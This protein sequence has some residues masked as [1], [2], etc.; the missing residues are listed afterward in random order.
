MI[1]VIDLFC[2]VGGLTHGF[3]KEGYNVVAGI[4]TDH[5]C[6][7]AYV[8]NNGANFLRQSVA[9]TT[10]EE[11]C[12]LYAS[13]TY[14]VLVGC[15]PCQQFSLYNNHTVLNDKWNLLDT[16]AELVRQAEP[17]VVSMENVAELMKYSI[18]RKFVRSLECYGYYVN[19]KLV[20]CVQYGIPQSRVRLVL[21]ASKLGKIKLIEPI[22]TTGIYTTVWDAIGDLPSLKAGEV[23]KNDPLH[24]AS[25]LTPINLKRIQ[26]SRPGGTWRDWPEELRLECHKKSSGLSYGSVYGRM[27]WNEPAPTMTTQFNGIGNGRFGHPV[28]NRAISIREGAIFQTFPRDYEFFRCESE[29]SVEAVTRHIGN[30]VPVQLGRVIARSI[31]L[32]LRELTECR[33]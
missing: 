23:D 20:N 27:K 16:F 2:G 33:L 10:A 26:A 3:L 30:A 21:L 31:K 8:K 6:E 24:R 9:D 25:K 18:F 17:D 11:L 4:D 5:T 12:S 13:A 28:Q 1:A 32:H 19:A 14:K 7:Y 22:R 15:A 29:F